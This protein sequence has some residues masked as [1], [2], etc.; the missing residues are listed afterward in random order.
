MASI[1]ELRQ[2][3]RSL[4]N[5]NKITSAMKLVSSS[6]LKKAQDAMS[7]NLP[8]QRSLHDMLQRVLG[9]VNQ[10]EI[11]LLKANPDP[12]IIRV[13]LV[14]SDKGLCGSFNS[15]LF[16]QLQNQIKGDWSK[17]QIEVIAFGK[18]GSDYFTKRFPVPNLVAK[19]GLPVKIPVSMAQ[20]AILPCIHD[21]EAG[22]VDAVFIAYNHFYSMIRQEPQIEQL[23]PVKLD[24]VK[25]NTASNSLDYIFEPSPDQLI[26]N[27]I[28]QLVQANVYRSMLM[29]ALG[30]NVARMNAM[31]N[32]T[33]NSKDLINRYTL[34][35]NRARQSAITTELSEIV[36]GAESLKN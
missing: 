13:I 8:Y 4:K 30:E 29:N 10:S 22:K 11:K 12:K 19:P 5:T 21:F 18:K 35:M 1:K 16:K 20:S 24:S 9:S 36:A 7:R 17:I 33:K 28:P 32:A 31:E 26:A 23:L 3:I 25:K 6:K 2:K 34:S 27:L 15:N 14:S